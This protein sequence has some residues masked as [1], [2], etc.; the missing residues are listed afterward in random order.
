MK[1]LK[2][3]GLSPAAN[4]RN[5]RTTSL[6]FNGQI[7]FAKIRHKPPSSVRGGALV[8]MGW[9]RCLAFVFQSSCSGSMVV[10]VRFDLASA[11]T[12]QP[13]E[14]T[15]AFEVLEFEAKRRVKF[16]RFRDDG[17]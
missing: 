11:A 1:L 8:G 10:F 13:L 9:P 12:K 17:L 5:S 3:N 2:S 15:E 7:V 14:F 6:A 16:G 4:F